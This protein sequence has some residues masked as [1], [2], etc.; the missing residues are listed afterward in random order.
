MFTI[1]LERKEN[2]ERKEKFP[3]LLTKLEVN[4][5]ILGLAIDD[6]GNRQ[7]Q[8]NQRKELVVFAPYM[9]GKT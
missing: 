9:L 7:L 4:I 5:S 6:V 8:K 3:K 1:K 2:F